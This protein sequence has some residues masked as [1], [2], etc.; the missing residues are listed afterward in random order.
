MAKVGQ[1]I[2][3]THH[4]HL[5]DI[6]KRIAPGVHVHELPAAQTAAAPRPLARAS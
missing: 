3:L 1:V 4:R 6:A 5:C 2:Y